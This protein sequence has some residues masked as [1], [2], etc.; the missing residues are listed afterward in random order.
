[1]NFYPGCLF[2]GVDAFQIFVPCLLG[3]FLI[4]Y[5]EK[6]F[7]NLYKISWHEMS[8]ADQKSLSIILSSAIVPTQMT[9]GLN[10]LDL[11]SFVDVRI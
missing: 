10:V 4:D 5:G 11:Q 8:L 9:S 3:T 7:E 2:L 6:Y 1:M